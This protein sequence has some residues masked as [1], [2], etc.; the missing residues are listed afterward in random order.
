MKNELVRAKTVRRGSFYLAREDITHSIF[1]PKFVTNQADNNLDENVI[2]FFGR[3]QTL[4][5]LTRMCTQLYNLSSHTNKP[6]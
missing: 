5:T 1:L 4:L 3:R 6:W 2:Y